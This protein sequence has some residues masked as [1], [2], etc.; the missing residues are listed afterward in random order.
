MAA[1]DFR[2][3]E[4]ELV[5]DFIMKLQHLFQIVYG[6]DGMSIETR[7]TLLYGQLHKVLEINLMCSFTVSTSGDLKEG[8]FGFEKCIASPVDTPELVS[9]LLTLMLNIMDSVHTVERLLTKKMKT[10][11][12]CVAI[13]VTSGAALHVTSAN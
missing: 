2:H 13:D 5:S 9:L 11:S 10:D 6:W 8:Y 1:Q 3:R 4:S 7:E 12:V